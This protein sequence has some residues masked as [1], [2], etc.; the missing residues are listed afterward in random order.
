[1]AVV[2]LTPLEVTRAGT[3]V[4]LVNASADGHSFQ[5]D[6]KVFLM[7]KNADTVAHTITPVPTFTVPGATVAGVS[8]SVAAGAEFCIG[9]WPP[10]Y[11][12]DVQGRM[13]VTLDAAT[14]MTLQAVHLP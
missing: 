8:V 10:Q 5:N 12:N 13:R 11:Y 1:M 14:S 2:P 7:G 3:S 9:P 4:V 6:G